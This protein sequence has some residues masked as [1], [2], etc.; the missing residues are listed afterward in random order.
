LKQK[1]LETNN[2]QITYQIITLLNVVLAQNY[3]TFQ[4]KIY[5]PEQG[6]AMGS[7]ISSLVAQIFL[8]HFEDI[9]IKP[10]LDTKNIAFT[11]D[12]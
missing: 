3:F 6:F 10:L 1:L 11:Q 7:P 12:T 2:K 4:Q 5:K 8:Q 9:H